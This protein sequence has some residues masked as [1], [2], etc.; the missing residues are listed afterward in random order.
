MA[1]IRIPSNADPDRALLV[2]YVGMH[3]RR[4]AFAR[5]ERGAVRTALRARFLLACMAF[6]VSGNEAAPDEEAGQHV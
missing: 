1:A 3:R 2:R 6:D 5:R 4:W